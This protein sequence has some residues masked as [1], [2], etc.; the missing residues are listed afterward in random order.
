VVKSTEALQFVQLE[1]EFSAYRICSDDQKYNAVLQ[2]LDEATSDIIA[3]V[4]EKPPDFDRYENLKRI[5]IAR[6]TDSEEK[7]LRTLLLGLELGDKKPSQLLR[8]MKSLAG[9]RVSD[10]LL[11][12]LWLQRLLTRMQELLL[13]FD[14][15]SLDKLVECADKIF[16]HPTT[17]EVHATEAR[18]SLGGSSRERADDPI[19][20]LTMQVAQLTA[21]VRRL[22]RPRGG[23]RHWR[24]R[25][26][27]RSRNRGRHRQA[28]SSASA[29]ESTTGLCYYHE[30]F[31]DRAYKCRPPCSRQNATG[32]GN[33][34]GRQM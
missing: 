15:S 17:L 9:S 25:S 11:R 13:I 18:M 12:T 16:E 24:D 27:G 22:E 6:L 14:N 29:S 2:H 7:Q 28:S 1:S 33:S 26:R 4:L 23:E 19:R 31:G 10:D 32:S 20:Q 8:E 5:L 30:R 21:Q 3:D 34:D